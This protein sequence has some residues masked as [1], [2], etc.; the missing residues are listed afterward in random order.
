MSE[1]NM[2]DVRLLEMRKKDTRKQEQESI[3]RLFELT[4]DVI[5]DISQ[6]YSRLDNLRYFIHAVYVVIILRLI[7]KSGM[8][9]KNNSCFIDSNHSHLRIQGEVK[10]QN[11]SNP[12]IHAMSVA[13][14]RCQ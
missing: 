7:V 13:V 11:Q 2:K 3:L 12:H 4:I 14:E 1:N 5:D 8:N 9:F 6:K 10:K